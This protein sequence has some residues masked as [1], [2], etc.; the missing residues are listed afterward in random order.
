MSVAF[1]SKS[2]APLDVQCPKAYR[3]EPNKGTACFEPPHPPVTRRGRLLSQ[4]EEQLDGRHRRYALGRTRLLHHP[5][6]TIT[7]HDARGH[8]GQAN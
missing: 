4:L 2:Y 8:L 7:L 5:I 6:A 1:A 3:Q